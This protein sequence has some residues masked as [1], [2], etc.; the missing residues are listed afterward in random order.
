MLRACALRLARNEAD[1]DDLVQETFAR[2]L[3]HLDSLRAEDKA[4]GWMIMILHNVFMD[5]CRRRRVRREAQASYEH[6]L[7]MR[8]AAALEPPPPW[9]TVTED[10]MAA[11][12]SKLSRKLR[13]C[14]VRKINGQSYSQIAEE[15]NIPQS[16][17]GTRIRRAREALKE[18]LSRQVES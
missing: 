18:M 8:T 13:E 17:V 15:L 7:A 14:Y 12:I 4:A 11:A 6:E 10:Q 16:T 3:A 5:E 2:A 9:A 1:A